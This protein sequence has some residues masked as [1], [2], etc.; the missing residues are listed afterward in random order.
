MKTDN[1][2]LWKTIKENGHRMTKQRFVILDELTKS[3]SHPNADELYQLVRKK[4]PNIS[5]GTVYRNL[6]TLKGL[7]LIRELNYGKSFS[8]YDANIVNHH[9]FICLKCGKV[10]DIEQNETMNDACQKV[11]KDI[12]F[13][14]DSFRL[15]F[16]GYCKKDERIESEQENNKR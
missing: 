11:F 12:E 13:E 16:Y 10:Y 7:K 2:I 8:R 6:K 14:I 9:H 5:F 15:E 1:K 3:K 4:I